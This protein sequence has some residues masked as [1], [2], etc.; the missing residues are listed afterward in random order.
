MI[1][2]TMIGKEINRQGDRIG[3]VINTN[4]KI[5]GPSAEPSGMPDVT[6]D[7]DKLRVK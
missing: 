3:R 1:D 6:E 5:M 4:K 7:S 2:G